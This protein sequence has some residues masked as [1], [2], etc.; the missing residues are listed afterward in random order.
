[1]ENIATLNEPLSKKDLVI[2]TVITL[3]LGTTFTLLSSGMSLIVTFVP[4]V[5]VT[6]LVYVWLYTKG[7]KLPDG[8]NFLPLF[9]TTL[10]VQFLHFAEEFATGFRTQFPLLYGG[11]PYS[12]NLFVIFNMISYFIFTLACI[13]VFTKKIRFLLV[14]VLFYIIYGA[15]GNAI[16][17]TYWSL[18]L[19]SYFPG[20]V[21][22]QLYWILG[23]LILY[24]LIGD[25]KEV[26]TI[27]ILFTFVL[28]AVQ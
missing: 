13:L 11:K 4:G 8:R 10:S 25:R 12:A 22:A 16:S 1:M 5:I 28:T 26:L 2:G 23:S 20:L 27:V 6:W 15:I 21:T 14:P 18:S 9:F 7:K 19:Q 3:A 24:K 17:H